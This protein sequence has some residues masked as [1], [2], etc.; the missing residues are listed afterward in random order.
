MEVKDSQPCAVNQA[1]PSFYTYIENKRL[2]RFSVE[3]K[4]EAQTRSESLRRQDFF[5]LFSNLE[6]QRNWTFS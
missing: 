4:I 1:V 3:Y 2:L 5:C 6:L